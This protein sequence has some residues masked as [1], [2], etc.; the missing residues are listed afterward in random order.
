MANEAFAKHWSPA[1]KGAD[2]MYRLATEEGL[3]SYSGEYYDNDKGA[4]SRVHPDVYNTEKVDKLISAT[5]EILLAN[6]ITTTSKS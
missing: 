2:I 1:N 4:F 6:S 3:E 5:Q